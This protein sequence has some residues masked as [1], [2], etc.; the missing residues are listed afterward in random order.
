MPAMSRKPRPPL[1]PREPVELVAYLALLLTVG[2]VQFSI[3]AAQLSLTILFLAWAVLL[4]TGRKRA[5]APWIF[6]P[7]AAYAALSLVSAALSRDPRTSLISSKQL[8]LLLLVPAVYTLAPGRRASRVLNV[9]ITVGAISAIIGVIQYGVFEY[10]TLGKRPLG[11]L[12]HYMTYSG[13]LMLMICATVAR[14]LFEQRDRIWP[15][16]VLPAMVAAVALT[17]TRSAWVGTATGVAVLLLLKDFRL[18]ALLPVVAAVAF[19]VAPTGVADRVNSM[20]T[21]QDETNRDRVAMLKAGV[22]IIRHHPLVG[23]GPSM[24]QSEYPLYRVPEAVKPVQ[25]HL[26]N[27]PVQIAAERGLPALAVWMWFIVTVVVELAR[28]LRSADRP[29]LAAAGL[30][31]VA[32]MLAAGLFEHN[33]GDSEFLMLFLAMITLPVAA[34]RADVQA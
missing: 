31:A 5:E 10:D 33:F 23:V 1:F 29:F 17:L 18:V 9:A 27:V 21:L 11:F 4:W 30:G 15:A 32:A 2:A 22:A 8:L 26:H 7:L 34:G 13:L 28:R 6:W 25:P 3:F 24:V 16:L 19:V 20:F 12:G 14:V